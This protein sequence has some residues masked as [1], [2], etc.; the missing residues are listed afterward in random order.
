MHV[1]NFLLTPHGETTGRTVTNGECHSPPTQ[2]V[3]FIPL[4]LV[5]VA[6]V[7]HHCLLLSRGRWFPQ[8]CPSAKPWNDP[9]EPTG[10]RYLIKCQ[11]TSA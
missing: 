10:P 3:R 5:A 7:E 8:W 11:S 6:H 1:S 4:N 9:T 2:R